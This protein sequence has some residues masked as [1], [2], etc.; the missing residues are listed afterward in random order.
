MTQRSRSPSKV[1]QDVGRRIKIRR[2]ERGLTQPVFA[3]A[4]GLS[5]Q[6]IQKYETGKC[7][8]AAGRLTQIAHVLDVPVSF[9]FSDDNKRMGSSEL[10]KLLETAYAV[11]LLQAFSRIKNK[12]LKKSV[13]DLVKKMA[14][15]RS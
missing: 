7:R 11:K 5:R 8:V 3:R 9:F 14:A 6:Q 10:P 13:L 15:N 4:L 12:K 1:D 2:H